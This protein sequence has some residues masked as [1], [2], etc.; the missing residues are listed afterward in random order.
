[1]PSQPSSGF[2]PAW[3]GVPGQ[4]SMADIVKMGRA[5]RRPSNLP[6]TAPETSYSPHNAVMPNPLHHSV[7]HPPVYTP[8]TSE[9]HHE[10]HSSQVPVSK[11]SEIIHE[12][13]IGVNQHV[14]L[15]DWTLAE[16][17]P[18]VSGPSMLEPSGASALF[19]D[20][21][22]SSSLDGDNWHLT[23]VSD[24]V[25]VTEG[26]VPTENLGAGCMAS[27]SVSD[28]HIQVESSGGAAHFDDSTFEDRSSHQPQRFAF[29]HQEGNLQHYH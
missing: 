16:Q 9:S 19:V 21:S 17:L 13:S 5:H 8:Q 29:E 28:R 12:P 14:S 10:L 25:Q 26:H 1:M 4:V 3:L 20:P 18:A 2:Q 27:A 15:D 6:I 23:S 11:V 7:N 22:P 24:E